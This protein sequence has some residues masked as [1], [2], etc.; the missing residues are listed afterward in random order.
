MIQSPELQPLLARSR[1]KEAYLTSFFSFAASVL[2]LPLKHI[3]NSRMEISSGEM[4]TMSGLL[5]EEELLGGRVAGGDS[6]ANHPGRSAIKSLS[7]VELED[8]N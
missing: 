8:C 7:K 5:L 2:D 4:M 1:I 3:V 6:L